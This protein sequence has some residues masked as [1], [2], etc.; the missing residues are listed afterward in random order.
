[1][2]FILRA[3]QN[4][5][6]KWC[7]YQL[8]A[9]IRQNYYS[10]SNC[11]VLIRQNRRGQNNFACYVAHFLGSQI[12]GFYSNTLDATITSLAPHPFLNP[13]WSFR[14]NLNSALLSKQLVKS[15]QQYFDAYKI[16]QMVVK[17]THCV[18]PKDRWRVDL[19]ELLHILAKDGYVAMK[20]EAEDRW[21]WSQRKLCQKPA[22]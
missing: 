17:P 13:Y 14:R 18:C 4:R 21:R 12:K 5:K 19:Q 7:E 6:I 11:M 8:R 3:K 22:A 1:M 16:R 10:I 2:P 15:L 20:L 9:K